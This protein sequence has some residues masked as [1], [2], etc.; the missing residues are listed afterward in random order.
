[1]TSVN[2]MSYYP[3]N[4]C[5]SKHKKSRS[6]SLAVLIFAISCILNAD[7]CQS[8]YD[9]FEPEHNPFGS[10]NQLPVGDCL[11]SKLTGTINS[12][13]KCSPGNYCSKYEF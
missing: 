10:S 12:Q 7:I 13:K 8:A 5:T 3:I 4:L 2:L 6:M 9:P 1:M 11:Y